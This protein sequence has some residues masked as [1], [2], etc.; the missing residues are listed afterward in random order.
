MRSV[1]VPSRSRRNVDVA[2]SVSWQPAASSSGSK[3]RLQ[4][5]AAIP[6]N[7]IG[8][9][10]G[11][12]AAPGEVNATSVT[13]SSKN[14]THGKSSTLFGIFVQPEP[15][16]SLAPRIV[17]VEGSNGQRLSLKQGRPYRRRPG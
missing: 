4:P 10:S 9:S 2:K 17:A 11:N 14:L 6:A 8:T 15:G 5:S 1:V 13:V 7:S 16:S 12:V 3:R